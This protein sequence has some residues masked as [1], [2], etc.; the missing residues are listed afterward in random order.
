[1]SK[2]RVATAVLAAAA[3]LVMVQVHAQTEKKP[4]APKV[5]KEAVAVQSGQKS[6]LKDAPSTF[7]RSEPVITTQPALTPQF[8]TSDY[9]LVTSVLD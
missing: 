1:M 6:Q 3:L 8:P 9:V 7:T 5:R 2:I 4:R